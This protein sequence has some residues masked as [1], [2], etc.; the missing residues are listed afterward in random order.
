MKKLISAL[1]S[2]C[3]IFNVFVFSASAFEEKPVTEFVGEFCIDDYVFQDEFFTSTPSYYYSNIKGKQV[4]TAYSVLNDLEKEYYNRIIGLDIGVLSFKITYTPNL[5]AEQFNS[6]NFTEIL[7]AVSLDHPELFYYYSSS[8]SRSYYPSSGAVVSVTYT[9]VPKKHG[10]TGVA[11]YDSSNIVSYN[12][13]LWAA[14]ESVEVDLSN[15]YNF[16][17]SVH[18]YLCNSVTYVN[19]YANCHDV[20]GTLVNKEAVCQGY[21]ETFKMFCDYYKVPCVCITGDAGGPHMWNAVQMD[22]GNWYIID[23]TWDDQDRYG[24]YRDFFLIGLNTRDTYF[25]GEI[26]SE[27]HVSDGSP[28][29]PSLPYS[30]TEYTQTNHNTGFSSTYNSLVKDDGK[31]LVRSIFDAYDT[32]VYYNGIYVDASLSC[33]N[34]VFTVASGNGGTDEEWSLVL[35]GDC[36][37]DGVCDAL[38]YSDVVNK[39]LLDTEVSNAY[40]MAADADCDG[41]ID[42]IDAA[43]IERAVNGLNTNIILD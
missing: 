12:K 5:T 7:H 40:D 10:Q 36:N 2:L 31:Y 30:L 35:V 4:Y 1:L 21:A 3:F 13:A 43:I 6:I 38:D 26:F 33:T 14:F 37:G 16:V 28:Y 9:I 18:D 15:R 41:Y 17:K 29:L 23:I 34:E 20:Y 8:C 11:I 24:I 39:V 32:Y 22:D 42:V 27:S 25:G 19:D